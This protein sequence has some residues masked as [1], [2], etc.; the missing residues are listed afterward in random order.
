[1]ASFAESSIAYLNRFRGFSRDARL[2]LLS[3]TVASVGGSI[4]WLMLN[5]YLESLGYSQSFIGGINALSALTMA[6]V[7]IPIG[8]LSDRLPRKTALPLGAMFY[9][10]GAAGV[11]SWGTALPLL[12]FTVISGIGAATI[13]ANSAPFMTEHSTAAQRTALFS[14]QAALT[15][16][17]G[18]VG[19]LFGGHLP[20]I[21][22]N[23]L[24]VAAQDVLPLQLTM[25]MVAILI[26]VALVPLLL[27][28]DTRR[29]A[30][31]DDIAN[32]THPSPKPSAIADLFPSS[33]DPRVGSLSSTRFVQMLLPSVFV[34]LGAG[35][36]IPFL[37]LFV[38]GKFG[39]SFG[40]LGLLFALSSLLTAAGML[41]QPLLAERLGKVRSV[42]VVQSLSLPF[43]LMMGFSPFFPLVAVALLVRGMLMNMANP[44]YMAFCMEQLPEHRRATFAGAAEVVW[45]LTWAGSS[46]FSGWWRDRVGFDTG[47]NTEFALMMVFYS[48]STTM[49]YGFFVRPEKGQSLEARS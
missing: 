26:V 47:F 19:N 30:Q 22:A 41:L 28:S 14:V 15:T 7:G 1:M 3:M 8:I 21:F 42:V 16:A 24:G 5:F 49:L 4:G 29:A 12:I 46:A 31:G 35:L 11:A 17:T 27:L 25:G 9:I 38:A 40:N 43:L 32:E 20:Q 23:W 2:F 13:S 34:G 45:S 37:N 10:V 48:I 39:I 36:T 6:V 44:V 33:T 18:F